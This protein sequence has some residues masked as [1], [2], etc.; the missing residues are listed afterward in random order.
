[1]TGQREVKRVD[2]HGVGKDG[3]ISVITSGV[4][5]CYVVCIIRSL[6]AHTRV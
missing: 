6:A 1:M 3:S 4:E 2:D 5:V